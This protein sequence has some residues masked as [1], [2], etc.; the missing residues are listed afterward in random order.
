MI[1][2]DQVTGA[3]SLS[4]HLF[5][6]ASNRSSSSLLFRCSCSRKLKSTFNSLPSA[7]QWIEC[8]LVSLNTSCKFGFSSNCAWE[9]QTSPDKMKWKHVIYMYAFLKFF[10]KMRKNNN[11]LCIYYILYIIIIYKITHQKLSACMHI[12][13]CIYMRD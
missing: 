13:L 3:D 8:D 5:S 6:T 11:F 10:Y 12:M 4:I 2:E 1:R 9:R 7:F